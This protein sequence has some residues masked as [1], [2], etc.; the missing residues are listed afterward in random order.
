MSQE[1]QVVQEALAVYA[2]EASETER[3]PEWSKQT[4]AGV[5]PEDWEVSTLEELSSFI[6]K[7]STPTTYGYKWETDGVLFLRSEC[8]SGNGLDLTQSMFISHGA[9][10][11]S[12][13]SEVENGDLL[14][15]ITGNV[16]R[17]IRLKISSGPANIN[18][19]I[20]RI[21]IISPRAYAGFIFYFLSQPRIR[22]HYES[23][24]TGQAYPQI[25]LQQVRNTKVYL[26]PLSE[27]RA[28]ATA[29]SDVDALIS[30]LDRLIS[31]KRAV[32]TAAMQQL[33]TGKQRLPEFSGE[34]EMKRLGDVFALLSTASNARSD[35]TEQGEVG[36]IHYGDIHGTDFSFLDCDSEKIPHIASHLVKHVPFLEEGD[37]VMADASEDYD[38]IGKS[39]EVKNVHDRKL[40]AGLHT[41]LLRGN[42]ATVADGF[43]GYLQYI[44]ALRSA[45]IKLATGISVYGISKNNVRSVEISLPEIEEQTA[46]A[47][48]LSD[49]DAEISALESRR[50]KTRQVKQGMMQE[51]LTG[52]TRLV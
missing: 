48:V 41:L 19:H 21:R 24:T 11:V 13:R 33:L 23:I 37:L 8:V 47:A 32:K 15:T 29:L 39:I 43:K 30:S 17:V 45:L 27:Q 20:A 6:T 7:G 9:H 22:K 36:Y 12:R 40:V 31:K 34:W 5:I 14:M 44:P 50:E 10:A 38:G 2:P 4:E 1:N 18:Q 28:I 16:G 25:S 3:A 42:K 46:I 49:M 35:L 51:L 26:P 52:R